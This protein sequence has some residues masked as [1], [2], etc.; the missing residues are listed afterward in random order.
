[1]HWKKLGQIFDA[2]ERSLPLGCNE[3]AQAPQA[4]LLSDRIRVYFTTRWL[5][6]SNGKYLSHVAYADFSRGFETILDVSRHE[7]IPLGKRGTFDEHGI[8]PMNVLRHEGEIRGYTSGVNRRISV[9]VDGA[10]GVAVSRNEGRTFQ[11]L[12]NGPV[13]APSLQEPCIAVDPFVQ[14]FENQFHMWYVFGLGWNP[15]DSAMGPDRLYKIGHA[16]SIDGI[17][18]TKPAEGRPIIADRLGATECQA[19]PT[20]IRLKDR[21]HMFFCFRHS[22]D[23]RTNRDRSYRIGHASSIDLV[24][25]SRD[26]E[27]ML[28]QPTPGA[29]DSDMICYPHVF[30]SDEQIYMLY[31]GNQFG[32]YG[33]GAA[34]LVQ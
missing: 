5:D 31:N 11:R 9:P 20:V 1:M 23:F 21:Y 12:G 24:T 19:M 17:V 13:L 16:V 30:E 7:V 26:D 10:I 6:H 27:S 34:V 3:F 4:L 15:S 28:I 18:W 32:R 25:W 2:S 14:V 8:F 33:F 29:W 22:S